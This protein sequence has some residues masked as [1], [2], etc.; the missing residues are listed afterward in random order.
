MKTKI[1][2]PMMII[3]IIFLLL[4]R[5]GGGGSPYADVIELSTQY[6]ELTKTYIADI[7]E[8]DSAAKVAD[9][10]NKYADGLEVI[11][12]QIME[13]E[14]KYPELQD[15]NNQPEELQASLKESDSVS[16]EMI[17]TFQKTLPYIE[18][19]EV[20]KAQERLSAI[21]QG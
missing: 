11:W 1:V 20:I 2:I 14:K 4:T 12:P 21:M 18:D 10:T 16:Q 7:N 17:G 9:A 15:T 3:S 5:C 13:M 8:S 6:I 19:P